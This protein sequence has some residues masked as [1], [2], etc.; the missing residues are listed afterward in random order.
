MTLGENKVE[1]LT[2]TNINMDVKKKNITISLIQGDQTLVS[3]K[4]LRGSNRYNNGSTRYNGKYKFR[5]L[6]GRAK[7]NQIT[8]YFNA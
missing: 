3:L 7:Q 1:T 8:M 2:L 5:Y 4:W 6:I